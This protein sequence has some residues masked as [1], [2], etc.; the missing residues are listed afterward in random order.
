ML[1]LLNCATTNAG[2]N[3]IVKNN[4]HSFD[5]SLSSAAQQAIDNGVALTFVCEFANL[6]RIAFLAW[7]SERKQHRFVVTHHALS[8]RYIV[9]QDKLQTPHLF[10]SLAHAIDFMTE[11]ANELF[12]SYYDHD[13]Q[14][15]MRISLSKYELPGPMRLNAFIS[16]EWDLD[17]GWKKWASSN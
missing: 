7:A 10:R 16:S 5:I 11:Q 4:A 15:H 17:S 3:Q 12:N 1:V 6:K 13:D 8:D 14:H 9:R 2:E